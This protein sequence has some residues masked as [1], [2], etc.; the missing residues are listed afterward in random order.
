MRL[1]SSHRN[2]VVLFA[3]TDPLLGPVERMLAEP[4]QRTKHELRKTQLLPEFSPQ[5]SFDGFTK[6]Q[7]ATWSYPEPIA[8]VRRPNPEQQDFPLWSEQNGSDCFALND[9]DFGPVSALF[10]LP[11]AGRQAR[12]KAEAKRKL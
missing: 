11:N 6:F 8:S 7:S 5:S 9:Q 10:W 3:L 12:L 1:E 2:D 4:N